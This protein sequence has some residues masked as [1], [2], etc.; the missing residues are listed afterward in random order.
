MLIITKIFAQLFYSNNSMAYWPEILVYYVKWRKIVSLNQCDTQNLREI[1]FEESVSAKS[2]MWT[3]LE[4]LK[5]GF[6]EFFQFWS[7]SKIAKMA[8][9]ELLDS[10]KLISR[11][12]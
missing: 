3:H 1:N 9:L 11:K 12:I 5:M 10:P 6:Y 7:A 2:V 4:A 8:G